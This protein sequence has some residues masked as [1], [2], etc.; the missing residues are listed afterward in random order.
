MKK[1]LLTVIMLTTLG[2][3]AQNNDQL[4]KHFE[5]YYLQ[6]KGQGDVQGVINALTHLNVIA[7][8]QARLDTLAYVYVSEG[9]NL[10][11]LNTIG[12]EKGPNDA[13][14]NVEVKAIALKAMNQPERAL[15]FYNELFKRDS[16]PY[17]AYEIADLLTINQ[18]FAGAK[19]Q[20][21]YGLINATDDM[22]RAFYESQRPYEVP[23]K[24]AFTYMKALVVFN[25]NK[26]DNL[27]QAIGLLDEAL[28]MA[29]NFNIAK[30]SKDA[31]E[32]RKVTPPKDKE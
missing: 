11:A 20:V 18:D 24:A 29:P 7:P 19:A 22:K 25:M 30:L 26:A 14:I 8:N 3:T 31:L 32:A 21:E 6:M 13:D 9:R 17:I 27:D 16:N 23:L 12:I 15:T 28:V 4:K 2:V 10:E 1:I 5:A